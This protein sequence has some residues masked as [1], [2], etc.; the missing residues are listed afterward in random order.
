MAPLAR[1]AILAVA[2]EEVQTEV[3]LG[4]GGGVLAGAV[5]TAASVVVEADLER[6]QQTCRSEDSDLLPSPH[7]G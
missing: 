2:L 3:G 6:R 7:S 4:A 5:R 1:V